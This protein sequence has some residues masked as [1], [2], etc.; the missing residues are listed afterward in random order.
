L[1]EAGRREEGLAAIQEAVTVY[2]R[3]AGANPAAYEPD[4]A[5]SLNNLSVRLA[6][7]GRREE[8]LAA[9]QEAVTVRRRLAAANAAAY[10]PALATALNNLSIRLA[11]A[12]RR[13]EARRAKQ[14]AAELA[15]RASQRSITCVMSTRCGSKRE[16]SL[17]R[18]PRRVPKRRAIYDVVRAARWLP[19]ARGSGVI[20]R[21]A[22]AQAA[23]RT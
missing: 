18:L 16:R 19:V 11:E 23:T 21:R 6:E 9:I 15:G 8:G 22:A 12:G 13:D 3:L 1:A 7:A 20:R 17:E 2:R 4:V 10:E 5:M 14:E